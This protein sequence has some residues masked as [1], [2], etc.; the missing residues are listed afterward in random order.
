MQP[1]KILV[2]AINNGHLMEDGFYS[3][4]HIKFF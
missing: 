4:Q 2:V 3:A 1:L